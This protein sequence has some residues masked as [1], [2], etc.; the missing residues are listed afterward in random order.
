M[1]KLAFSWLAP[2]PR[3]VMT[4]ELVQSR[5]WIA[6]RHAR[7]W[8]SVWREPLDPR[9]QKRPRA[10]ARQRCLPEQS[11]QNCPPRSTLRTSPPASARPAHAMEE[12]HRQSPAQP[13][14][15]ES[16]L[17]I[18]Q[19]ELEQLRQNC[20]PRPARSMFDP[21][22]KVCRGWGHALGL[23]ASPTQSA[24]SCQTIPRCDGIAFRRRTPLNS[25]A[26]TTC[27]P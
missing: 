5:A 23:R 19:H 26:W 9:P 14:C 24:P 1:S 2:L 17:Q 13:S 4:R 20:P 11:R 21:Q 18:L 3:L 6:R 15:P 25:S 22:M 7:R 16:E 10:L 12:F 8:A 27:C